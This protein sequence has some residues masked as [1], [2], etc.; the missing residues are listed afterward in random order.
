M[1]LCGIE[2]FKPPIFLDFVA[3]H[4]GYLLSTTL[5]SHINKKRGRQNPSFFMPCKMEMDVEDVDGK[6]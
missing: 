4:R 6:S 1:K 5:K 2:G 3:L